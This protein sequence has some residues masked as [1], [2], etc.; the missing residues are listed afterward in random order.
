M[1]ATFGERSPS[2]GD[3]ASRARDRGAVRQFARLPRHLEKDARAPLIRK[4]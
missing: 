1:A 2:G 3:G 4:A